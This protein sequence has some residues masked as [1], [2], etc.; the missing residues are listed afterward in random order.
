[1]AKSV[2]DQL[3][4]FLGE[5]LPDHHFTSGQ[6]LSGFKSRIMQANDDMFAIA[7]MIKASPALYEVVIATPARRLMTVL[8]ERNDT[9]ECAGSH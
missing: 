4:A 5:A 7:T 3:Q 9:G 6:F 2:D 1:M 8:R